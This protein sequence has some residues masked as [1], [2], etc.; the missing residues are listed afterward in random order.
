MTGREE[1]P[2]SETI[3]I[4]FTDLV[5]STRRSLAME[6]A[7]GDGFRRQHFSLL[8]D[9]IAEAGGS[10]VKS[11]GDGL[12]VAFAASSA[13]L[14]CAIAMQR[15]VHHHNTLTGSDAGLRIGLSGGEAT[16]EGA[17]YFGDPVIEAAR[18]C[19]LASGGQILATT[20]MLSLAGRRAQ[21]RYSP[22]GP[23]E[24][25]GFPAP[26]DVVEVLWLSDSHRRQQASSSPPPQPRPPR[27]EAGRVESVTPEAT[28]GLR[29]RRAREQEGVSLREM[30][31]RLIRSHSNLWDYERGHR[32][33]TAE[34]AA[35][36]ERELGLA[37][38]ELQRPLESARRQV[39]GV[40]RDRRRPF[41]PAEPVRRAAAARR[42][43]AVRPPASISD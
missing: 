10:E 7:A 17:D 30:A 21:V 41:R 31:R 37:E 16:R 11:L 43:A 38:G 42:S 33:A 32:L 9:A 20:V 29:L 8:R 34:I 15:A 22:L 14:R 1:V 18:L 39:Y 40:D 25:K 27:D 36:Y 5:D 24:L 3:A 19:S 2:E 12:M 35:E 13:A 6:P 28:F 26:V 23:R 4:L